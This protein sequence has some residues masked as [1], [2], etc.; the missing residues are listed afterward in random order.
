[1]SVEI[2]KQ[3]EKQLELQHSLT[4]ANDTV[5]ERWQAAA[6]AGTMIPVQA[7]IDA[8]GH[9]AKDGTCLDLGMSYGAQYFALKKFHPSVVWEGVEIASK[10]VPKFAQR[11]GDDSPT[12]HLISDYKDLSAFADGAYDVVTSRSMLCHYKP[13]SGFAIL[14]EMLR[15]A[16]RAVIVKF[17]ELPSGEEDRYIEGFGN[18][19]GRGYFVTWA[20][21]KWRNYIKGKTVTSFDYPTVVVIEK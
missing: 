6:L 3:D 10:Y 9:Y 16:R 5:A 7:F 1:M 12:T 18:M 4:E 2:Y 21:E 8:I 13:E 14:D 20:E 19:A 11:K 15:V 17:Y